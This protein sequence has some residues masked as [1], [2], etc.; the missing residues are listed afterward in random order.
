MPGIRPR[1]PKEAGLKDDE[2]R[3]GYSSYRM[4]AHDEQ[5][6]RHPERMEKNV[7]FAVEVCG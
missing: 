3:G 7:L 4:A 2:P 5:V 1:S 6:R